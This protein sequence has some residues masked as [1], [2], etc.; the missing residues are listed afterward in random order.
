MGR[1]LKRIAL[2]WT[3]PVGKVW[4]GYV[5]N[6][7]RP[8]PAHGE[9]CWGGQTAAAWW[10]SALGRFI[11]LLGE[12][13]ADPTRRGIWP[14]PYI[15]DF[16]QA[17]GEGGRMHPLTP[18]LADFVAAF[19]GCRAEDMRGGLLASR[20]QS[21]PAWRTLY[22][23][24]RLPK[25]WGVCAVC[26][27]HDIHPDDLAALEAWEPTE[28]PAGEG[29]QL[30]ETVSEGSPITPVYPT[31]EALIEHMTRP[32]RDGHA[33][34]CGY[35]RETAEAFVRGAGWAPSAI[36]TGGQYYDGI[37]GMAVLAKKG[38]K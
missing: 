24:A 35:S 1:E 38:G 9:D 7:G 25:G 36:V 15:Q 2:D 4:E 13:A 20:A 22:R 17:P 5:C 32:S 14:H 27:G 23:I 33:W 29:W 16:P 11:D 10:V 37:A 3:W 34:D 8:C 30:W 31:A 19:R 26:N 21:K 18:Q 12:D 28:P 6:V